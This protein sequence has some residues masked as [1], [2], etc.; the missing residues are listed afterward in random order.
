VSRDG[1]DGHPEDEARRRAARQAWDALYRLVYE[2]EGQRRFH[3]AC[4]VTGLTPSVLKTLLQLRSPQPRS[5]GDLADA[6]RCDPS[7]VTSLVDALEVAGLGE[8]HQ[9]PTDRRVREVALTELGS[10]TL[11]TVTE[12]LGQPPETF[13]VLSSEELDDLRD[14]ATKVLAAGDTSSPPARPERS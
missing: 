6:F 2:G 10:K 13:A 8:R 9:H 4:D 7:Y 1:P 11:A 14:L 3:E 5:M 12:I